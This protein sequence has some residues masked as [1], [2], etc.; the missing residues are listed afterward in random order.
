M[1]SSMYCRI[2]SIAMSELKGLNW[3]GTF[4]KLSNTEKDLFK[5]R[6]KE[7]WD[8]HFRKPTRIQNPP[9]PVKENR[10]FTAVK[11]KE[12]TIVY[13]HKVV[14]KRHYERLGVSKCACCDR[15]YEKPLIRITFWEN[16]CPEC[17]IPIEEQLLNTAEYMELAEPI[18][19]NLP[20]RNGQTSHKIIKGEKATYK[21][22]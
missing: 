4:S 8:D 19:V 14:T 15:D 10:N 1:D 13:Y 12:C 11:T 21:V 9:K 20:P 7:L 17:R 3:R 18:Y 2:Q 5:K 16:Y 22:R 6:V